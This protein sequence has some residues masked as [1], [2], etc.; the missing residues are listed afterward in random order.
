MTTI[1]AF[2]A[3]ESKP[4]SLDAQSKAN[5]DAWAP[6]LEQYEKNLQAT[7]SEGTEI[8]LKRH[9]ARGQLLARDR[10]SLLLDPDTPFLE[11]CSFA[12]F[13]LKDS[14]PCA[15][16]IAGIG[17]V[18]G[19]LCLIRSHVPSQS[20]GAWNEYTVLKQN[21][22]TEIANENNLPIIALIQSAGV[23][24]PQQFKVFHKGGQLFRDLALR[25][26]NGKPTCSVVFGSSTA[27]GAYDPALSDYTIFVK[28]QAQVFLGGP[29]LV[30]MAT[31]EV[32][33]AESLGGASIHGSVTGLA[34]QIAMDEFDAVRKARDWVLTLDDSTLPLPRQISPPLSPRYPAEEI[35][36]LVNPDIRKPFDMREVLLRIV[37]DSRLLFF[38]PEYGRNLLTAF[39]RIQGIPTAII[40]N[41]TPV[42]H[43]DEASKGAQF[44]RL[45][46]QQRTPIVFLHNVT[47][48]MVGSK[49][50]HSAIIKKGAQFVSAVSCSTVPHIS[51]I[52]GAS[53]GAGNYAMCGRA[54][55]PRFLFTWPIGR[56]SVMGPDQLSGVMRTV[57]TNSAKAK[58][59][60]LDPK[61]ID[62]RVN[63]FR[64]GVQRDSEC[65]RTSSV[66]LDDGII[67]PRDTRDVLGM[68]L[69]IVNNAPIEGAE[70]HRALARM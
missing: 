45:C 49:A 40:A 27:G 62:A 7:T 6:V 59:V 55:R 10:I 70:A 64:D 17:S 57:E 5:R 54:Y 63:K 19:R 67:D 41:Q 36:S 9:Q 29:P 4:N 24:L 42:I 68:C 11:L 58:G 13:G 31:G 34:D 20:G 26:R 56:C 28:D 25:S 66:L 22:V 60:K 44:I 69:E 16:L 30:K 3:I 14:S 65:Y 15:S 8:S 48:F 18:C 38:K 37:D 21:R 61:D 52:L 43:A 32:I 39:T 1:D 2:P 51:V 23:F 46:N 12:G 35:L 53:Y 33:D 50:E 47:G